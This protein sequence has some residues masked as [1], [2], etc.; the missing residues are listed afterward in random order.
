[1]NRILLRF[2]INSAALWFVDKLFD[3]IWFVDSETLLITAIVFGILNTIIKPILII[4]TL[5]INLLTLGLFTL[6]INAIILEL[7]DFF[8]DGF[9][10]LNFQTA[11][12]ASLFISIIS[13]FLY[14]I[15]KNK[16]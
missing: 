12:F 14:N 11:L 7:T 8:I 9:S 13:I 5:P 6:V 1:M 2:I 10:I 4:F 15:L 16:S 3:S